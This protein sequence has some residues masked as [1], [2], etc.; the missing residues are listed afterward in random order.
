MNFTKDEQAR[1]ASMLNQARTGNNQWFTTD[2]Q[3]RWEERKRRDEQWARDL[4]EP[5]TYGVL[6]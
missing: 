1:R 3:K 5:L 2:T 4:G 6:R